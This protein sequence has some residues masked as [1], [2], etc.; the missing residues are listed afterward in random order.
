MI[1][2][3]AYEKEPR[4]RPVYLRCCDF[5]LLSIPRYLMDWGN[6]DDPREQSEIWKRAKKCVLGR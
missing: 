4:K 2:D 3:N 5:I 6:V 1:W